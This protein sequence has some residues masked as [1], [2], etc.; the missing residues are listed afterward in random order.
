MGEM[1]PSEGMKCRYQGEVVVIRDI[2]LITAV[3]V[4]SYK[5]AYGGSFPD[6]GGE[7]ERNITIELASGE[8]KRVKLRELT[9]E[10]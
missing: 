4:S 9:P 5:D 1:K 6:P 2:G 3:S 8:Q 10:A 7:G